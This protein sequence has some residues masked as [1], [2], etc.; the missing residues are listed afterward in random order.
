[1]NIRK[2][3]LF[4]FLFVAFLSFAA[5]AS[6]PYS[7]EK[8]KS[9]TVTKQIS[10]LL[11][12]IAKQVDESQTIHIDFMLNDK[13]EIIVVSTDSNKLD[14]TIKSKLNYK[15]IESGSLENFK[16]YTVPVTIKKI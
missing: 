8:D 5:T 14:A 11:K 1:M 4:S 6:T 12:G 7:P 16:T 3:W 13:S 10:K 2:S 9:S 15:A